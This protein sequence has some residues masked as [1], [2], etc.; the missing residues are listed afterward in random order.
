MS[1]IG[2]WLDHRTGYRD[3]LHEALYERVPGGARWRYVWGS[4]LAFCFFIQMITGFFLWMAYSPNAFGAWE[5]V[6][7]IQHEMAGG[8]LLRGIHHFTAQAMIVLLV[9]HLMQVVIDGAYRAPRE[10]NFWI[11]LILMLI[12]LGL[13]LTG[14]LLP[15]DQKGYWAT[16]VATNILGITPV[17]GPELQ[18]LVIGGDD[19][20]HQ[21][22]TRFFAIHAG[23]LP[24]LLVGF[25]VLHIALFRRHGLTAY[26]VDPARDSTFWPD[27]V[28][29][30][31]VACLAVLAVVLFLVYLPQ[32]Q[33]KHPGAE[34]GPPASPADPYSAARPEW[35]FLFLFQFL[36]FFEGES[37]IIG[38]HVVPGVILFIMALMPFVGRWRLGH[39]FN[40]LFLFCILIGIS[41]LT[42]M[43]LREDYDNPRYRTAKAEANRAA[44]RI[45][46][47]ITARGGIPVEGAA[48]LLEAD[49]YIQGPKLFARDCAACHRYN[50]H[51]GLGEKVVEMQDGQEVEVAATAADLGNFGTRDWT[52]SV[53]VDYQNHFAPLKNASWNGESVG[54]AFLEEGQMAEWS[55]AHKDR[56]TAPANKASLDALVE[57]IAAQSGRGDLESI[58]TELVAQGRK[59][60]EAGELAEGTFDANCVDCHAIQPAGEGGLLGATGT[61]PILTGYGGVEWLKRFIADPATEEF[62]GSSTNAMPAFGQKLTAQELDILARWLARDYLPSAEKEPEVAE[63]AAAEAPPAEAPA[64]ESEPEPSAG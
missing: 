13:S 38:A 12:V 3:F 60:F 11:G 47:L 32:L 39:M 55:A 50:G 22:L 59:I 54:A 63:P 29:R 40:V 49:P 14:Y 45:P 5:S 42:G 57:F 52:R 10:F 23:L 27:Q 21:T 34:L 58:N 56:L 37:E 2:D 44:E 19:Y 9:L 25:L 31:A 8:W 1:A 28:L 7:Y 18:S 62:Y 6:Y 61:A 51:N 48:A 36:K 35:Y 20:G 43:A 24:A 16:K 46:E 4:T 26:R 41:I 53:L 33:G 17:I 15:W 30:D 64:A